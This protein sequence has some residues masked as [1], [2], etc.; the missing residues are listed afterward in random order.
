LNFSIFR[1][2]VI[3]CESD[4]YAS[5]VSAICFSPFSLPAATIPFHPIA[6]AHAAAPAQSPRVRMSIS[7]ASARRVATAATAAKA[8]TAA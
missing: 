2:F 7:F 4:F 6:H 5:I 3:C 8:A 1:L